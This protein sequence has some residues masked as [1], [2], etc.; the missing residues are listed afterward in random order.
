MRI[1]KAMRL[2]VAATIATPTFSY[3]QGYQAQIRGLN[4]V[5]DELYTEMLPLCEQLISVGRGIAAFAAIFYI[6]HRVWRHIAAAEPVDFYPLLRPFVIG[7]AILVF[8][9][10]IALINAVLS[11]AVQGT[12]GMVKDSDKA[13]ALLL[14]KKEDA[15]K[16]S[17]FW[18]MYVGD[19]SR[20]NREKWLKYMYGESYSEGFTDGIA[21]DI[22]FFMAKQSYNFRNSIKAA[23]SE[24]LRVLFEAAGL[25]INTI[26][27]FYLIVLAIVGPLAFGIAVF[28]GFQYTLTSWIARYINVFL[29]LPVANIF[30]AIIGKIQE[31]MIAMDIRQIEGSGDTFF[32]AHDMAYLIFLIIGIV[33]Y[34][35]VPSV[36]GYIVHAGPSGALLQKTTRVL[37]AASSSAAR[38]AIPAAPLLTPTN[39]S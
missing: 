15:I 28:D 14:K 24:I 31:K 4:R 7:F 36:A 33:G 38:V 30:G 9:T 35:S 1:S 11:P 13:I 34:F 8:P 10:V 17:D 5:L 32:N 26:R 22:K 23:L 27:T 37:D 25:C 18:E 6:G 3:A 39:K 20:G 19:D 21:N 16:N 12:S 29:W 2:S